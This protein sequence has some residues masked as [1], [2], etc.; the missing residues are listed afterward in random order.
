ML[1]NTAEP[2][3]AAQNE[4]PGLDLHCLCKQIPVGIV[5]VNKVVTHSYKKI[6]VFAHE[7]N[8]I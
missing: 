6:C 7:L 1:T 4:Q 3:Q 5:T 8:N 2:D